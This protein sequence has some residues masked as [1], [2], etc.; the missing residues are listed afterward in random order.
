LEQGD[1]GPRATALAG[2][3]FHLLAEAEAE[4][5]GTTIDR[6]H[7]HEV[8]AIDSIIDIAG[9]ALALDMLEIQALY[10][11]PVVTGH[12]TIQI[13]HGTVGIPAPA[14]ALL[15]R[16][17]PTMVGKEGGEMATPTGAAVLAALATPVSGLPPMVVQAI[18]AGAGSREL[19][20]RANILRAYLGTAHLPSDFQSRWPTADQ[21]PV[22][23][24]I[25]AGVTPMPTDNQRSQQQLVGWPMADEVL[26]QVE[27]QMDDANG[28]QLADYQSQLLQLGVND[29]FLTSILM[30]KGRPGHLLTVLCR[31]QEMAAVQNYLLQWT[32]TIGL[33][34][35]PVQRRILPRTVV[36]ISSPWGPV[37]VKVIQRPKTQPDSGAQQDSAAQQNPGAGADFCP[38]HDPCAAIASLHG[39]PLNE[40]KQTVIRLA[41]LRMQDYDDQSSDADSHRP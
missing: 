13:D 40:V 2:R 1:M 28:Q 11:S 12:G 41:R 9:V 38:E 23:V 18:G 22:A 15:L 35:F 33:R 3:I 21:A 16:G 32:A 14:T 7:F 5:H 25:G 37:D 6:V 29:C 30:K 39:L 8:G 24:E 26:W 31:Q 19:T 27:C 17:F 10:C 4:V 34:Y 20:S 36:S